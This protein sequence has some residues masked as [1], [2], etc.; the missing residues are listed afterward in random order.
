MANKSTSNSKEKM[1][2]KGRKVK[3][4]ALI[5]ALGKPGQS[6]N[7]ATFQDFIENLPVMF[8]AVEPTPP[9][10]PIYISPTFETF[11]YPISEW[12]SDPNIWDRIIHAD[13]SERILNG[14][15]EA[16]Q[17][18]EGIDFEYRIV[19]ADGRSVWVR[20]QSCFI[21]DG[22]GNLLCWRAP[23]PAVSVGACDCIARTDTDFD[24]QRGRAT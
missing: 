16:M 4:S 9:Y 10:K 21:K 8:Y 17:T 7:C 12:L 19:C 11:G 15:R 13:D 18:G 5:P 24:R 6:P 20:D 23:F 1:P 14:T 3:P 22:D 2:G